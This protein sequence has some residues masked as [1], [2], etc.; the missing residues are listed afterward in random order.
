MQLLE[1]TTDTVISNHF[2][3]L[4]LPSVA[5]WSQIGGKLPLGTGFVTVNGRSLGTRNSL[6]VQ[7]ILFSVSWQK[8]HRYRVGSTDVSRWVFPWLVMTSTAVWL[9]ARYRRSYL[10]GLSQCGDFAVNYETYHFSVIINSFSYNSILYSHS[11]WVKSWKNSWKIVLKKRSFSGF[12]IQWKENILISILT[13]PLVPP[14]GTY[15]YID[16]IAFAVLERK[17]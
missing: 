15:L 13:K 1:N 8:V 3:S 7:H 16:I 11:I 17:E 5:T 12:R 4:E 14:Q 2:S 10:N 9:V 6:T